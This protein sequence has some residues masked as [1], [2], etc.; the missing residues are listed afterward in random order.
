MHPPL[1]E[2]DASYLPTIQ[3]GTESSEL[4]RKA[5]ALL[6]IAA[7]KKKLR[8]R[9]LEKIRPGGL[10]IHFMKQSMD[11]VEFHRKSGKNLL[12]MVKYLAPQKPEATPQGE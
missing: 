11:V 6:D 8:G 3:A 5:S 4:E 1:D 9:A 2:W 12:R 7:D 10:G